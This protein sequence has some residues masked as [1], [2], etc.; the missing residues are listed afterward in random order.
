M[1]RHRIALLLL[2]IS[3]TIRATSYFSTVPPNTDEIHLVIRGADSSAPYLDIESVPVQDGVVSVEF[4]RRRLPPGSYVI[5][6]EAWRWVNNELVAFDASPTV[7]IHV[8]N[9]DGSK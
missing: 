4:A 9:K 1:R 2:S 3:L 5:S 8:P 7:V 6:T